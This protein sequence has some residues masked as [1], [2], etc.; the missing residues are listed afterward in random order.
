MEEKKSPYWKYRTA[1][2]SPVANSPSEEVLLEF[3]RPKRKC[4]SFCTNRCCGICTLIAIGV[5]AI[6]LIAWG[7]NPADIQLRYSLLFNKLAG[8]DMII[9]P[10][11]SNVTFDSRAI[12]VAQQRRLL[13]AGSIHYPRSPPALW[14][15]LLTK[16]RSAG[17]NV[18]D[19]YVFWDLHEPQEG[20]FVWD[21]GQANLLGYLAYA[22]QAGLMVNLRLGP[23]ACAE[24]NIGGMPAWLARKP[25]IQFRTYNKP[26]MN[27][28]ETFTTQAMNAV[29]PYLAINGGPII[30]LQI[31]NEYGAWLWKNFPYGHPYINWVARLAQNLEPQMPWLMCVQGDIR[32]VINTC[33]GFYC[34][35]SI[36][37]H[38]QIFPNQ[39]DMFTELWIAW[40]QLWGEPHPTRPAQDVAF[41]AARF[42]AKGG[43]YVSYYMWHGG[44][45]F[46]R[47]SGGPLLLT[48]Y[49]YDAPLNEYGFA[50]EPKQSHLASLNRVLAQYESVI[51]N[52]DTPVASQ[53]GDVELHLYGLAT[54]TQLL[55][56]SNLNT[57][58][59]DTITYAGLNITMPPK[60]VSVVIMESG[61][62]P[63]V[64]Y[65][66][67][68]LPVVTS[69]VKWQQ[70]SSYNI[71]VAPTNIS[72]I[73]E[74]VG[75]ATVDSAAVYSANPINQFL[76]T[77]DTTDYMWY[78]CSGVTISGCSSAT[79]K[80]KRDNTTSTM[81]NM[82]WWERYDATTSSK[83]ACQITFSFS[84]GGPLDLGYAYIDNQ[85]L[86]MLPGNGTTSTFPV[87]QLNSSTTHTISILSVS[88]GIA[89]YN[90]HIEAITKGITGR[91]TVNGNDMTNCGWNMRPGLR[92]EQYQFPTNT[93]A[94]WTKPLT[95]S[96]VIPSLPLTWYKLTFPITSFYPQIT[97][98]LSTNLTT[99]VLDLA[100]MKR[101][102]AYVNGYNIGRYWSQLATNVTSY[103]TYPSCVPVGTAPVC[104]YTQTYSNQVCRVGC[105]YA[106]QRYYHVPASW[107]YPGG[108]STNQSVVNVVLLEEVG[109]DVSQVRIVGMQGN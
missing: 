30:L 105:G 25:G 32:S 51:V 76:I 52:T 5:L 64:V 14:P 102:V 1:S 88:D 72:Y 91:V 9:P 65:N 24:Y 99:Y 61:R 70:I 62:V 34:D 86:G 84:D 100:S 18:L 3:P 16:M 49:D 31:E 94:P 28:M 54:S 104:D 7:G 89:H 21:Q 4:C 46:A 60:S 29:R 109:G 85:Y 97:P 98:T 95:N 103:D 12:I 48:A 11:S 55:F 27:A 66:T 58:A 10:I 63:R 96:T 77:N 20:V 44:T 108:G 74:P 101:G 107:L 50:N 81:D 79:S 36:H 13:I 33:N 37:S 47:H 93:T 59:A 45:N 56:C 17:V 15:Y 26:W 73:S 82:L 71:T 2:Y 23:Y 22:Q 69:S 67:A 8:P 42:F 83:I 68:T 43:T 75:K 57:N 92:G 106:S 78:V 40:F 41:S 90:Q 80:R 87:S 38:R 6:L 35:S 39:P 53:V 19:T